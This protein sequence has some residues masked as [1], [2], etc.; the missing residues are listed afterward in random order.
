VPERRATQPPL[1]NTRKVYA[2]H[3]PRAC[4]QDN[5]QVNTHHDST[6]RSLHRMQE[7]RASEHN[8]FDY[9]S[10]HLQLL[11]WADSAPK[12]TTTPGRPTNTAADVLAGLW[13]SYNGLLRA[14]HSAPGQLPG[15]RT[16]NG[17]K[18]TARHGFR[19]AHASTLKTDSNTPTTRTRGVGM[20][21]HKASAC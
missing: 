15:I 19:V 21:G 18:G 10:V 11:H 3:T 1:C 5:T 6:L 8:H 16:D 4:R 9:H 20:A 14:T 2:A 7:Q 17:S 12:H 13:H